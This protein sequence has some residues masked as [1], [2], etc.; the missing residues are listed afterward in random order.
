MSI[1][2]EVTATGIGAVMQGIGGLAKDIR[3]AIVGQEITAEQ[4]AIIQQKLMDLEI[5]AGK[6]QSAMI[7][8]EASS[9]DP[10]TSRAR[11]M[12]MYVF[13]FILLTMGIF[14]PAIGVWFPGHSAIF[15]TNVAAGF[16][17]IPSDLY[18]LF[19]AGY[20]GYVGMRGYEKVKGASK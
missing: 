17:A 13:Y 9:A 5:E 15:Y 18:T 20:L 6:A 11:P 10:M 19:G 3:T 16:K 4:Q 7:V 1:I 2:G 8:A 14:V 12:F